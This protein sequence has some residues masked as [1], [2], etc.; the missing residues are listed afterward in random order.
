MILFRFFRDFDWDTLTTCRLCAP[1][2]MAFKA[3]A[4]ILVPKEAA[5]AAEAAG[6]GEV[7]D[8]DA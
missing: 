5:E 6:A 1:V 3:G 8:P 7:A 4:A 2:T